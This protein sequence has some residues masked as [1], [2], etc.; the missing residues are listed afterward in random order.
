M[1]LRKGLP[2][3]VLHEQGQVKPGV[4]GRRA[5]IT[6]R[7]SCREAMSDPPAAGWP[8]TVISGRSAAAESGAKYGVWALEP[9][10]DVGVERV[11]R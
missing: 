1:A 3:E 9:D 6:T 8:Q 2:E 4:L 7:M 10:A 5:S 11:S